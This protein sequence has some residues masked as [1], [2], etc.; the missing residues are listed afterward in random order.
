MNPAEPDTEQLLARVGQGDQ[1][2][3]GQLLERHRQ[4]LRH[5]IALR[6]DRRLQA[7]LDPSDVLQETLAE[8]ARRLADSARLRPLPFSPWLRQLGVR[9]AVARPADGALTG[10][11]RLRACPT[12]W[13]VC[14]QHP[15]PADWLIFSFAA[16]LS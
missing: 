9:G 14:G 11:C 7:R 12:S 2:A 16:K 8:P 5:L 3:L 13:Q 1:A 6:L 15:S 10:P 4:R